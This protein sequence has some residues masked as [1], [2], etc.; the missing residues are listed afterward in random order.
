MTISTIPSLPLGLATAAAALI[1]ALGTGIAQTAPGAV[2][3]PPAQS[4][5]A[6]TQAP[7][8]VGASLSEDQ[9]RERLKQQGYSDVLRLN[10]AGDRYEATAM[11]NGRSIN[12]V[13]DAR[14]G[15]IRNATKKSG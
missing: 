11:K 10:R 12:L 9:V 15:A 13:I 14:T 6:G 4:P 5:G 3:E 1:L 8:H 7:G 2:V